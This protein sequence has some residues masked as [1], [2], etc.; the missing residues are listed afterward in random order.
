MYLGLECLSVSTESPV[1]QETRRP[2]QTERIG[3]VLGH[4]FFDLCSGAE[5]LALY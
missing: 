4:W 1:S 3:Q 2:G 5:F